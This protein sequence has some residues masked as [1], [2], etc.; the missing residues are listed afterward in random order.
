MLIKR[1]FLFRFVAITFAFLVIGVSIFAPLLS[2]ANESPILV[3][4]I[5]GV[6]LAAYIGTL[7]AVAIHLHIKKKKNQ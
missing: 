4:I 7:I 2:G 1:G 6:Y 5:L 3:Y